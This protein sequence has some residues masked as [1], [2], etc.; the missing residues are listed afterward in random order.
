MTVA[1]TTLQATFVS[2]SAAYESTFGWYNK[3]TGYGG[4]LFA[5]VEAE[6]NNAPLVA[7]VSSV[8]FTVNTADLGNIEFFLISDGYNRNSGDDFTGGIKVIRLSDGSWAV[9]NVDSQGR[10]ITRNGNPD[11]LS[12]AGADALFTEKS[13]NEGNVDY[14][15]SVAGSTQT[16]ATLAGDTADGLTGLLA[17]EDLAATRNKNGTYS[18]PG[19]ADYNDAVFRITTANGNQAPVANADTATVSENAGATTIN[20]LGNDTDPN[21]GD[22]LRVQSVNTAGLFGTVTIGANGANIAYTPAASFQSL[23]AGQTATETFSYTV[24]DAAGATSTATVTVTIVGANDAAV[25]GAATLVNVTEDV[26]TN[27]SGNLT[28]SGTISISDVDQ[29]QS[30]F[31]TGVTGSTGNLGSLILATNGAYTY[32]VANAAAQSLGAGQAKVDTFTITALDGTTQQISFTIHGANDGAMIGDPSGAEVTEDVNVSVQGNL[33]A[34]GTILISDADQGQSSFASS[35]GALGNLG[36]LLLAADG[37]YTYSVANAATQF[38][39]AGQSKVDTFTVTALDGTTKQVSFTIHGAN[40]GATIGTPTLAD[41][42]EDVGVDGSLNLT[43]SGTISISDIDQQQSSFQTSV[44]GDA[45][46]LGGLVLAADGSYTYSVANAATQFL[47]DGETW[48]DTFTVRALDGTQKQVSFTIHGADDAM[49]V[50]ADTNGADAVVEAGVVPG[51]SSAAGNVLSNDSDVDDALTVTGVASGASAGPVAGGVGTAIAGTYGTL[52]LGVDG[53]WSYALD[54]SDFDT[55][56]LAQNEAATD[57]FSY[58][59]SDGH[60][61]SAT[62]TLTIAIAG[63]NDAPAIQLPPGSPPL[64][65]TVQ[66][67]AGGVSG[68]VSASDPDHGAQLTWNTVGGTVSRA[69]DYTVAIDQFRIVRANTLLFEDNFDNNVAP[70]QAPNFIGSTAANSY[71]GMSGT[72]TETGGRAIMDSDLS[73]AALGIGTPDT[74]IGHSA[75]VNTDNNSA[76]LTAG[77]KSNVTF[78][79]EGTFDLA[80]PDDRREAYG[81]RLTDRIPGATQNDPPSKAGDDGLDLVVR[82]GIDGVVRVQL[83][84][85]DFLNDQYNVHGGV[86]FNATGYE[87]IKLRLAHNDPVNNAGRIIASFDLIDSDGQLPTTTTTLSVVGRIFGTETPSDPTDNENWT[88]AQIVAYAPQETGSSLNGQ[89]GT[90]TVRPDGSYVYNPGNGLATVQALAIGET[91]YDEFQVRVT[92]EHGASDVETVRIAVTGRNDA[93]T[94]SAPL[95][96][97]GNEG[98]GTL[99]VNL[100]QNASDVDHGAVLNVANFTWNGMPGNPPSGFT[101]GPNGTSLIIDT[102]DPTYQGL[103]QGQ[104]FTV[105]VSYDVVDQ[106]GASVRQ[107]ATVT[108]NG[109]SSTP[110]VITF[111]STGFILETQNVT[112]STLERMAPVGIMF[113]DPDFLDTH[114]ATQTFVSAVWHKAGGVDVNIADPGVLGPY[115]MNEPARQVNWNYTA[116]DGA[117]DFLSAGETVTVTY[118]VTVSDGTFVSAPQA[119]TVTLSGSDDSTVMQTG[120][121]AVTLI[122]N[123]S[124]ISAA[125][126][127]GFVDPDLSNTHTVSKMVSSVTMFPGTPLTQE[128]AAA[129]DNALTLTLTDPATGDGQGHYQWSFA[130][131][132]SYITHFNQG[133]DIS[134]TYQVRVVDSP[135]STAMQT[136]VVNI[137]GRDNLILG[138]PQ[139]DVLNGTA[140]NFFGSRTNDIIRA[141]AGDDII[142]GDMGDDQIDGGAGTDIAVFSGFMSTSDVTN[143]S[144]TLRVVGVEGDDHLENIEVLQFHDV[145]QLAYGADDVDL[146]G[147]VMPNNNAILGTSTSDSIIISTNQNVRLIDLKGG[148]DDIIQLGEAGTPDYYLSLASVEQVLGVDDGDEMVQIANAVEDTVFDLGGGE[149]TVWLLAA[150]NSVKLVDVEHVVSLA[151]YDD[152]YNEFHYEITEAGIVTT[153]DGSGQDEIYL[154]NFFDEDYSLFLRGIQRVHG[155]YYNDHILR[156]VNTSG[157]TVAVVDVDTIYGSNEADNITVENGNGFSQTDRPTTFH[158]GGG[159]DTLYLNDMA[160]PFSIDGGDYVL[161]LDSVERIIVVNDQHDH[162]ELENAIGGTPVIGNVNVMDGTMTIDTG[163]GTDYVRLADGTNVVKIFN[164]EM[165]D[166]G[167]GN[168]TVYWFMDPNSTSLAENPE[169]GQYEQVYHADIDMDEGFN[170]L[171]LMGN[172]NKWELTI[173][174]DNLLIVGSTSIVPGAEHITFRNQQWGTTIDLN[175]P[176]GGDSIRLA[177]GVDNMVHI[178]GVEAVRGGYGL[179]KDTVWI[180]SIPLSGPFQTN[181]V[182]VRDVENIYGGAAFDTVRLETGIVFGGVVVR[183]VDHVI[184]SGGFLAQYE[185][186]LNVIGNGNLT[187][188][189]LG[190]SRDYVH[191]DHSNNDFANIASSDHILFRDSLDSGP[192]ADLIYNFNA[193]DD[194]FLFAMDDIQGNHIHYIAGAAFSGTAQNPNSTAQ[195]RYDGS[196][197]EIDMNG[198]GQMTNVDMRI[199]LFDLQGSLSGN[200]FLLV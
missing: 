131:P 142:K 53:V 116:L 91:V 2:E 72:F 84:E 38:L 77:L 24:A 137:Q 5:D 100:L 136:I 101:F 27:G 4:I 46:N 18:K 1:T 68:Q 133:D 167:N 120:T 108:I 41:V 180:D 69:A 32:S 14:A 97:A 59:A 144:G 74:F 178:R 21:S 26:G 117:L 145:Y 15:S 33:T 200:N 66:E 159:F 104:F 198:D 176:G 193:D 114:T 86:Q 166:S 70:P 34:T 19:D 95:S 61:G 11:I 48:V 173:E 13:K 106:H 128:L 9:A 63:T 111:V 160:A 99:S 90:L 123:G 58:T 147:F 28:A 127:S 164:A 181:D 174:G 94:V 113:T 83:V 155:D 186:T 79:V 16:A 130:L 55:N 149:D 85:V 197:V 62:S 124:T 168:D 125:G 50:V 110:P 183:G 177:D 105:M 152:V 64:I 39:G 82:M 141:F 139:D 138:T 73:G 37:S 67:D 35:T 175:A 12:G 102:N 109:T 10:V 196:V 188:I 184:G 156:L 169:T 3:V 157:T 179:S 191:L 163:T 8:K 162:I 49:A 6:G 143:T 75:R 29:G 150:G 151:A 118:N 36:S 132:N 140:E 98:S 22:T 165:L 189:E 112:G 51:D 158:A 65:A 122:E 30:S 172:I 154:D 20:V 52:T 146:S 87:Q 171:H 190:Q 57:V 76:N 88:R 89:Y 42:T 170:T 31:Q 60:G 25:I 44:T 135:M 103:S 161:A 119:V 81:I 43:A 7:G 56:A 194:A 126:L 195:A 71:G 54:N 121:V 17:W 40:D 182:T 199:V 115:F 153:F 107:N 148:F 96:R 129:L 80:L 23:G 47:G 185:D 45:G 134:V 92:D 192:L 93:P 187:T 78:V